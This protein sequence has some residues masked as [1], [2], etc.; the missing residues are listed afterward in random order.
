[1]KYIIDLNE[2]DIKNILASYFGSTTK[3]ITFSIMQT[4]GVDGYDTRISSIVSF[5]KEVNYDRKD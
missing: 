2:E 4:K 1:M 3:D 5:N